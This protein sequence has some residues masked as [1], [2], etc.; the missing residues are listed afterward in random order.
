[1]E[2]GIGLPTMIPGTPGEDILTLARR[3]ED[4]GF[5]SLAV[6]DRLMY[7]G[8]EPLMTLAAAAG[9][10]THIRLATTILIAAYRNDKALLAKQ[11][12]SLDRLSGGR[13]VLGVA[14]GGRPDDYE[15]SGTPYADRG[16]RLDQLLTQLRGARHEGMSSV[17]PGPRWTNGGPVLLVGG[18]SAAAMRRAATFG[19]GWIAGGSSASGYGE[20]ASKARAAWRA[21]GRQDTPR[22][23]AIAYV[24][25]G[26]GARERAE[27]YLLDYYAFIGWK[28]DIAVKSIITD[29]PALREFTAAYREA[30]CDELI[31]FP[32]VPDPG[33][34]ELIADVVLR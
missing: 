9:A 28:A 19:D 6:L 26:A 13:L 8:Y 29:A 1:M 3:C 32:G 22:L 14:A 17:V 34:A 25:L 20:L 23:V 24:A 4:A 21:A 15:A 10:T 33:Q 5:A 27:R 7:D 2:F 30:G 31:L 12:A 16:R 11:L 18:H